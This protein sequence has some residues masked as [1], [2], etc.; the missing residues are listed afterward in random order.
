MM[1]VKNIVVGVG[2]IMIVA[3]LAALA[4]GTSRAIDAQC[5][6]R[7][8]CTASPCRGTTYCQDG[9]GVWTKC[10]NWCAT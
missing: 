8:N 9:E 4:S 10:C 1:R 2:I 7:C 3:S 6:K 5:F